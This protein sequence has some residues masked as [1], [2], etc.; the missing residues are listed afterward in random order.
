MH[1]WP[2][3]ASLTAHL[4]TE[5]LREVRTLLWRLAHKAMRL[6]IHYSTQKL[7]FILTLASSWF[8]MLKL[9]C[10]IIV[11]MDGIIFLSRVDIVETHIHFQPWQCDWRLGRF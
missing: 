11:T 4:C 9:S 10:E 3:H 2:T 6:V 8:L 7:Y 1:P 5:K